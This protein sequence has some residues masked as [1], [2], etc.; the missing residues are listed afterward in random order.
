MRRRR[1]L[2]ATLLV[3]AFVALGACSD[4]DG[5]L[6]LSGPAEVDTQ[7]TTDTVAVTGADASAVAVK[8]A[9]TGP[10]LAMTV[11]VPTGP[12]VHPLSVAMPFAPVVTVGELGLPLFVPGVNVTTMSA[13]GVPTS[14]FTITD[15]GTGTL[16]PTIAVWF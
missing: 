10:A 7:D 6:D 1:L 2:T 15:G 8:I 12:S 3:P 16:L 4:D 14:F 13:S 9:R 5:T 11:Y